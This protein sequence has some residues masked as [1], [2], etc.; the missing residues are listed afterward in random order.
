LV[1]LGNSV[2]VVAV[3]GTGRLSINGL[4]GGLFTGAVAHCTGGATRGNPPPS[5]P[6]PSVGKGSWKAN[7]FLDVSMIGPKA[8]ALAAPILSM[9]LRVT[10][11]LSF[12]VFFR[13]F[14]M[15][16]SPWM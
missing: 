16:S 9:S 1:G 2:V 6:S 13:F 8:A 11:E 12:L 7:A 10:L 14:G 4:C 3:G 5:P 15:L